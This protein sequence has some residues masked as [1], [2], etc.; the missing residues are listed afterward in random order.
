MKEPA[1]KQP[2]PAE[3]PLVDVTLI[4]ATLAMTPQKR[5]EQN[6]RMVNTILELKRGYEDASID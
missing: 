1:E 5:L 4:D 6:D 3:P 2:S